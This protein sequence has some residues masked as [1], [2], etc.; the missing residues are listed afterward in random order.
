MVGRVA[1]PKNQLLPALHPSLR[2]ARNATAKNYLGKPAMA[3]PSSLAAQGQDL[4]DE[5][6]LAPLTRH[7]GRNE[8]K[9]RSAD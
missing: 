4:R 7:P 9:N 6:S 3:I 2:H 8:Q 5:H 1:L